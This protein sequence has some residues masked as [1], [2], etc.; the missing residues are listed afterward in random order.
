ML[1]KKYK[2]KAR[3]RDDVPVRFNEAEYKERQD[4][5]KSLGIC[6]VCDDSTNLDTPHHT[7]QGSNKDDRSLICICIEC[8][9]TL[10]SVGYE[11]LKKSKV[12]LVAIGNLNNDLYEQYKKEK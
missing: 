10:H 9:H 1:S 4:F 8:H 5:I 2:K 12:Q 7:L 11:T 6:Q 3:L